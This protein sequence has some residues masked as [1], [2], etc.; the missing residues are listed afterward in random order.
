M[1]PNS[2]F[3]TH[4]IIIKWSNPIPW[5]RVARYDDDWDGGWYYITRSIHKK[6]GEHITPL[7]IGKSCNK[8]S[9]RILEH[10]LND[11]NKPFLGEYG[12]LKVRFGRVVSPNLFWKRYHLNR[13]L[14]TVESALITEVQ[15]KN[16]LSQTKKYTRWYKLVIINQG[17]HDR[18]PSVIDNRTH[19]NVLPL[20]EWWDGGI[21]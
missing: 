3:R 7:Y 1:K 16:N 9:K 15:P 2:P 13:F 4:T 5:D 10:H 18:I 14:L 21:E 20:P 6:D 12:E 8:I 17:K 11:S 19:L